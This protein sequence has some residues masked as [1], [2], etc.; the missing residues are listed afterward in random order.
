[1]LNVS[2]RALLLVGLVSAFS[3]CT[4]SGEGG[5]E[6]AITQRAEGCDPTSVDVV[7]GERLQLVVTNESDEDVYEIEGIEGTR[8]EEFVVPSGKTR[9]AGF[10]VP[11]EGGVY[12][13]KCYVPGG[14]STIIELVAKDT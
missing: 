13:L 11:D 4:E 10:S 3:A 14:A 7:R 9:K 5:R 2:I 6:I 12:P 8:L 1:M